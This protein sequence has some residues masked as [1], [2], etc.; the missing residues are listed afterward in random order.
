[1]AS[2]QAR[3]RCALPRE[4]RPAVAFLMVFHVEVGEHGG[5]GARGE[6]GDV[7]GAEFGGHGGVG[8]EEGEGV[9]DSYVA[10]AAD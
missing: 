8:E 9:A 5:G 6:G 3:D 4:A 7:G 1:M 2:N 10:V